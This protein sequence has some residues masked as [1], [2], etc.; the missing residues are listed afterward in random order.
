MIMLIT[1]L[2]ISGGASAVLLSEW[3]D[4]VRTIQTNERASSDKDDVSVAMAGDPAM[5]AHNTTSS[6]IT[7]FFL[8]TGMYELNSSTY[9]VLINGAAPTSTTQTVLPSGSEWNP[10][11]L[12]EVV[13][14][15]RVGVSPMERTYPCTLSASPNAST[16]SPIQHHQRGG[17][18]ECFRLMKTPS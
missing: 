9:E 7:L 12:L 18:I 10:G 13:S 11:H 2:L 1:A 15:T 4:A 16:D 17:E 14:P 8:N 3:S 5:V 6:T